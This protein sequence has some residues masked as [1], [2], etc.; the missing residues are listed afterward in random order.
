MEKIKAY[1]KQEKISNLFYM[2]EQLDKMEQTE[3]VRT[4]IK[5]IDSMLDSMLKVKRGE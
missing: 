2:K 4:L 3:K 5:D 1:E